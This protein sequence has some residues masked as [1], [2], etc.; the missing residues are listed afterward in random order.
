MEDKQVYM[1]EGEKFYL[2]NYGEITWE[3]DETI[4]ACLSGSS[5]NIDIN[6]IFSIVLKPVNTK[7]K[8]AEFDF[9]KGELRT[10]KKL[11]KDDI[12]KRRND[13]LAE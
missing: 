3:Q 2:K 6:K 1:F 9:T 13:F 11:L 4:V 8:I 7:I 10:I 5:G 12:V